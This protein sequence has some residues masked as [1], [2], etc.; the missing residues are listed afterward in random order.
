MTRL[1]FRIMLPLLLLFSV[2][3]LIARLQPYDDGGLRAA[4]FAPDCALLCFMG[5]RPGVT[6]RDQA[7]RLLSANR[8]VASVSLTHNQHNLTWTWNGQEPAALQNRSANNV[9]LID[10]RENVYEIDIGTGT[11]FGSFLLLLGFPDGW[12]MAG[13]GV[14]DGQT[15]TYRYSLFQSAVYRGYPA[16]V[17]AEGDCPVSFLDQWGLPVRL[18]LPVRFDLLGYASGT[19]LGA[20][21]TRARTC[22]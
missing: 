13:V 5:I 18:S 10:N 6:T 11:S 16:E 4:L 8:W 17:S 7:I 20:M 14:T 19:S 21:T 15:Q 1:V 12:F 3:L 22:P 2:V 9:I